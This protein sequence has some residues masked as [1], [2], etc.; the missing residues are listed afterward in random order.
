MHLKLRLVQHSNYRAPNKY[1]NRRAGYG[2]RGGDATQ[3]GMGPQVCFWHLADVSFAAS[4]SVFGR[5]A[6]IRH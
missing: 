4:M 6:D 5:K 1:S 3:Y 2:V